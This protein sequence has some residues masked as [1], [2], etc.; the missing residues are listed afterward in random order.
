MLK[1]LNDDSQYIPT[2]ISHMKDFYLICPKNVRGNFFDA[3]DT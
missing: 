3:L 2:S 1:L